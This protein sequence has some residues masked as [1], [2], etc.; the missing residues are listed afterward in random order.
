MADQGLA[1][2]LARSL[3]IVKVASRT[4]ACQFEPNRVANSD[5]W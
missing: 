4:D 3:I 5:F 1:V 2:C